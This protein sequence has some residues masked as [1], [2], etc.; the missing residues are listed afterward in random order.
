MPISK[1]NTTSITD[2]SVT[3]GKIV[4]GAVDADIA[5]GSIDTAQIADDAVTSAKL[6]TDID[7]AGNLGVGVVPES[8]WSNTWNV[9]QVGLTASLSGISSGS[10]GRTFITDNAYNN[11]NSQSAHWQYQI[12]DQASQI[13]MLDGKVEFRTATAGSADADITWNTAVE[14][15]NTGNVGVGVTPTDFQNRKSLDIGL[16]GKVWGLTS[17]TETGHGNNFYFDGA[18]K[19]KVTGVATRHI[20]DS[21][22][23]TFDVVASGNANATISWDTAMLVNPTGNVGIGTTPSTDWRT[24]YN[25]TALQVGQ[26]GSLFNLDV[27]NADRRCMVSS[28]AILNASGDFQ[29]IMEG[30]ATVYSQQSGTHRWYSATSA[31]SGATAAAVQNARI[32]SEGAFQASHNGSYRTWGGNIVGHQM[33]SNLN[34]NVCFTA[35]A[36]D[37]SFQSD[38]QRILCNRSNSVGF[39]F[40]VCTS[41]DLG[42][43]EFKLR[44]DG[45][46]YTDGAW[47]TGGADYAEYFETTTGN[48]IPRG[49]TVVLDNNKVRAATSD[50]PASSIIGVI[51]P[52][53]DGQ[54]SAMVGNAGWS[55]WGEK[56]LTDDFGV[57]LMDDH[58]VISFDG[59][60][61]ESH[62]VPD[63]VTIPDDAVTTTHDG[64]GLKFKH[65]RENP[66]YDSSLTYS[67][68]EDRD[69][70]AVVGLLGQVRILSGQTVG[71]RWIKMRDISE[72]VEEWF[73]R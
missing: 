12:A 71:D 42:D 8:G 11:S 47:N 60:S 61:Y 48:A 31:S 43:D 40:L 55:K 22:G 30:P 51:R 25:T 65:R 37:S 66:D 41:G 16:G 3:A 34:N 14:V 27:S 64:N 67:P 49:T 39:D 17:A 23:H 54:I 33:V 24:A 59:K 5:A 26:S 52:K 32:I 69:E 9:A 6:D 19:R 73:I 18:Y 70:W 36:E 68:R 20:Q 56:Y 15:D 45:Q 28:N 29:H 57:Y 21:S 13:A 46:A 58:N 53:D 62:K 44:G 63:D 7:I 72:T 1:I 50:D 4:A 10:T 2:N 35:D 38:V